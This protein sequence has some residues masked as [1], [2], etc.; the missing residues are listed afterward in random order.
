MV[1][2]S[3]SATRHHGV[4]ATSST[5]AAMRIPR[6][7]KWSPSTTTFM[8]FLPKGMPIPPSAPSRKH[9]GIGLQSSGG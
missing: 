5:A 1:S 8:G 2:S 6:R 7:S 4:Q 9:N 3:S